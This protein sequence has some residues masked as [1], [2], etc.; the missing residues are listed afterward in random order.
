MNKLFLTMSIVSATGALLSLTLPASADNGKLYKTGELQKATWH[1]SVPEY[2]IEDRTPRVIRQ[3]RPDPE[4]IYLIPTGL[5]PAKAAPVVVLPDSG[6]A[7][8]AGGGSGAGGGIVVPRGYTAVDPN[9]PASARFGSN[10]PAQGMAPASARALPNGNSTNRLGG[11]MWDPPKSPGASVA[12]PARRLPAGD[13]V[14]KTAI[15]QP[16]QSSGTG[17]GSTSLTVKT[18]TNAV[19]APRGSLLK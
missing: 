5:A 1:K 10:I 17:S 2:Y 4:P 16:T 14:A 15:Y 18:S 13:A 7:G 8:G 19:L 11:E 12:A 6:Q 3:S 9:H